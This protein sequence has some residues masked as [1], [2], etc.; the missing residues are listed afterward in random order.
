MSLRTFHGVFIVMVLAMCG[1]TG[2]WAT[3]HNA[4]ALVTPWALYA[5]IGGALLMTPYLW[6]YVQKVKLPR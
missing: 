3:G 1:V 2:W 4:A 6:W 5:S